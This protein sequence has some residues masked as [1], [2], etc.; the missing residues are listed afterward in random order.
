MDTNSAGSTRMTGMERA[1]MC[2][3]KNFKFTRAFGL[4]VNSP[5]MS[6]FASKLT[7]LNQC[8]KKNGLAA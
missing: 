5:E 8:K 7:K 3:L 4:Q 2:S 1:S 6:F